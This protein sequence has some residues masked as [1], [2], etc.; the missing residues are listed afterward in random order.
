MIETATMAGHLAAHGVWSVSEGETLIPILAYETFDG[1]RTLQRYMTDDLADAARAAQEALHTNE[2]D[3]VRA[4]FVMDTFLH[5]DGGKVDALVVEAVLY[6]PSPVTL[7]V[8]VPYVPPTDTTAFV[9][10]RPTFLDLVGLDNPDF[11]AL[12]DAFFEGVNAHEQASAVWSAH[13]A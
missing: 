9:V 3:A 13:E 6:G 10:H 11:E 12:G 2:N 5:S 8:A 7:K 1:Q 4:V